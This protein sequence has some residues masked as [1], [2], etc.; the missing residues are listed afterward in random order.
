VSSPALRFGRATVGV[1][2]ATNGTAA[3]NHN[4]TATSPVLILSVGRST[5]RTLLETAERE[6]MD[7]N[8]LGVALLMLGI[9]RQ[10]SYVQGRQPNGDVADQDRS[11]AGLAVRPTHPPPDDDP[12]TATAVRCMM[13]SRSQARAS[14]RKC[15]ACGGSR[16]L[17][18]D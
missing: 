4:P 14:D 8:S 9:G 1:S 10:Q 13:C 2:V 16:A 7:V 6:G 11:S 3:A 12:P 5:F 17:G 18:L 15:P